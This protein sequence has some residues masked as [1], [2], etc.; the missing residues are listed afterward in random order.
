MICILTTPRQ[1][2][3]FELLHYIFKKYILFENKWYPIRSFLTLSWAL[4]KFC[5]KQKMLRI[6][7][8]VGSL[9]LFLPYRLVSF[10]GSK[11]KH[12]SLFIGIQPTIARYNTLLIRGFF[13]SLNIHSK[14]CFLEKSFWYTNITIFVVMFILLCL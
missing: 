1:Q 4:G 2:H 12:W 6:K 3:D 13:I 10:R 9:C 14:L 8:T 5:V 11:K 7:F